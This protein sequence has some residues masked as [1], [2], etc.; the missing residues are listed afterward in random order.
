[1]FKTEEEDLFVEQEW[2]GVSEQIKTGPQAIS[3]DILFEDSDHLF[4]IPERINTFNLK[5][6][7]VYERSDEGKY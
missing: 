4:G 2:K 1:M 6:T 5:P 3:L 7:V